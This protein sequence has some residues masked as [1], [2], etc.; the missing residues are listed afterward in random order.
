[1]ST[2]A[3]CLPATPSEARLAIRD[4]D[5]VLGVLDVAARSPRGRGGALEQREAARAGRDW[6]AS[7][8]LRDELLGM[9]VVVEDTRDGQ[10]WRVTARGTNG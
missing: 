6:A 10:R 1:M 5:R 4:F 3:R 9:G 8:R 7:D 2:H